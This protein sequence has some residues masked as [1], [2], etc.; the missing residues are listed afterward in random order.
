MKGEDWLW[1]AGIVKNGCFAMLIVK[2]G[3]DIAPYH[4]RQIVVLPPVRGM[5]W[6]TLSQP[7]PAYLYFLAKP[8]AMDRCIL[9]ALSVSAAKDLMAALSPSL[10]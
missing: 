5:E 8:C 7:Q 9:T 4:D 3:A 6:L 10:A 2:P 1:I